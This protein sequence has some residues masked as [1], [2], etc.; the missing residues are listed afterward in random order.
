MVYQNRELGSESI[1]HKFSLEK[2][3]E[4]INLVSRLF[5]NAAFASM[6]LYEVANNIRRL[7][8]FLYLF[9]KGRQNG[10]LRPKE[11]LATLVKI[12]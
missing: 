10:R 2:K 9:I 8:Q 6:E 4:G 5:G 3:R 11:Y 1:L 7:T 12:V